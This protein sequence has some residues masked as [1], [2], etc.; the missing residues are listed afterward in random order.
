MKTFLFG[1]VAL[2]AIN[3]SVASHAADVLTKAPPA[4]IAAPPYN[5]SGFY[6][7]ANFGGAWTNGNLNIP[8]NSFY[9]GLTE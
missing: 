4:P 9:G 2:L 1:S 6:V 8:N 5:W 7:G 3:L